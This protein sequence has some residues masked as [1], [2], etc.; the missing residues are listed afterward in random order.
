MLCYVFILGQF[1]EYLTK[2]RG[3]KQ[4]NLSSINY[5]SFVQKIFLTFFLRTYSIKVITKVIGVS[6]SGLLLVQF[7]SLTFFY[8]LNGHDASEGVWDWVKINGISLGCGDSIHLHLMNTVDLCAH[9]SLDC[10]WT[11]INYD[12]PQMFLDLHISFYVCHNC[13]SVTVTLT[14]ICVHYL[15]KVWVGK[16]FL[17]LITK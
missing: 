4:E 2:N 10:T 11:G 17:M 3:Q 15:S 9:R 1:G 14:N 12:F 5:K 8:S 6:C 13:L 16:I 7:L